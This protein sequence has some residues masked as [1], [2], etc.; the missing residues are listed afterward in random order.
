M[1][2][3]NNTA[4]AEAKEEAVKAPAGEAAPASDD[5]K[6]GKKFERKGRGRGRGRKDRSQREAKEFEEAILQIDRVTRVVKGGRRMRFRITVVI[7]DKKGR[8]G[9]GIGKSAE[10]LT[11]IQKAV[12]AAKKDMI[13]VPMVEGTIPHAANETFKASRVL[14]LPAPEGKG[15]IAGG[16][17]RKILE[18][19]GVR[20]VLSKSHGS[21]NKLNIANATFKALKSLA[22]EDNPGKKKPAKEAVKEEKAAPKAEKKEAK[23]AAKKPAAKKPAAK[24]AAPK[25]EQ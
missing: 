13:T 10:V 11:G 3:E 21:R 4:P 14:L 16:A 19:A 22:T 8:V 15:V 20:N 9:F 5:S 25:K 12:A 7:G 6:D 24:K 1:T 18:L 17:V 2:E 23:P